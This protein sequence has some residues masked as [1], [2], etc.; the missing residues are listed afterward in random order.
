MLTLAMGKGKPFGFGGFFSLIFQ[1]KEASLC[2][3]REEIIDFFKENFSS[4]YQDENVRE[5]VARIAV[6]DP[7][8]ESDQSIQS[9]V[10][11]IWEMP[12]YNKIRFAYRELYQSAIRELLDWHEQALALNNGLGEGLTALAE[13][14]KD[15]TIDATILSHNMA[16]AMMDFM[17]QKDKA[18]G[19]GNGAGAGHGQPLR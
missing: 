5:A 18:R 11:K 16:E 6:M 2:Y 12:A 10:E 17:H 13:K 8:N 7:T 14:I 4:A 1:N 15:G 3:K 9:R 19:N